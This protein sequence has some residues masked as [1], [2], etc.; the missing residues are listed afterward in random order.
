MI[1][2]EPASPVHAATA[3]VAPVPLIH[4]EE[5]TVVPVSQPQEMKTALHTCLH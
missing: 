4:D 3:M 5:D 1:H 2:P